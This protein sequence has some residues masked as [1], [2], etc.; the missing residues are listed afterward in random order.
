MKDTAVHSHLS[1]QRYILLEE[2][3]VQEH[4]KVVEEGELQGERK[5]SQGCFLLPKV[6]EKESEGMYH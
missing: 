2:G 5:E 6:R 3:Y 4:G 1:E